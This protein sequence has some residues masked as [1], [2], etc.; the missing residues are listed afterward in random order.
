MKL[1]VDCSLCRDLSV[2]GLTMLVKCLESWLVGDPQN[3]IMGRI[4]M[5]NLWFSLQSL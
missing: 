2:K 1:S 3:E 5:L 4:G